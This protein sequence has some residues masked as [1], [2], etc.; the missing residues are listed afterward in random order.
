[1]KRM[2]WPTAS[3]SNCIAGIAVLNEREFLVLIDGRQ[4]VKYNAVRNEWTKSWVI[5]N[6]ANKDEVDERH[7]SFVI[8][9]TTNKLFVLDVLT[10][11]PYRRPSSIISRLFVMDSQNGSVLHQSLQNNTENEECYDISLVNVNGTIHKLCGTR[12]KGLI[13]RVW[14]ENKKIWEK[15][16]LWRIKTYSQM[17]Q[18]SLIH[19]PSKNM[20]VLIGGVNCGFNQKEDENDLRYVGIWSYQIEKKRWTQINNEFCFGAC[21]A[22]LTSDEDYI[23]ISGWFADHDLEMNSETLKVLDVSSGELFDTDITGAPERRVRR[24]DQRHDEIHLARSGGDYSK[25]QIRLLLVGWLRKHFE[26]DE[27]ESIPSVIV[28][29]IEQWCSVC[30]VEL[31]HCLRTNYTRILTQNHPVIPLKDILSSTRIIY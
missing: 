16:T 2:L 24:F 8:D 3:R 27:F 26:K 23:I 28:G 13:H 18:T 14:D 7:G 10:F 4:V 31:I 20:I 30:S 1:M 25:T 22:V 5:P 11:S 9:Q 21:S 12:N 6:V 17:K 19:V 29:I 15:S